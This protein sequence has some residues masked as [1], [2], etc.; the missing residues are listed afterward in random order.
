MSKF[1]AKVRYTKQDERG[2]F[3]RV[4]EP[5]LVDALTFTDCEARI[6]EDLASS[7]RGE[8]SVE[9]IAKEVIEEI[10]LNENSDVFY[11]AQVEMLIS[12]EDSP[13][14]KLDVKNFYLTADSVKDATDKMLVV[15][16]SFIVD[17]TLKSVKETKIVDYLDSSNNIEVVE[18][19][20]IEED[21]A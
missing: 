10:I 3:K 4:T 13:K 12:N 7:I 16:E 1:I 14:P 17:C 20:I 2:N 21:E 6:Y 15:L 11:K 9:A 8:F 18:E 19:E 5:Y